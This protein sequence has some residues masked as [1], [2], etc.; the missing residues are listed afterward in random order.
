MLTIRQYICLKGNR[1]KGS[2]E[3]KPSAY[4]YSNGC[5]CVDCREAWRVH[6]EEER[7]KKRKKSRDTPIAYDDALTRNQV[8]KARDMEDLI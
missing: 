7:V 8:L 2:C 5:R 3:G 6:H 1:V 4:N